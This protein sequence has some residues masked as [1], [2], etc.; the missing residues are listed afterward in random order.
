ME[1]VKVRKPRWVLEYSGKDI[2]ANIAPYILDITYNDVL[3]GESDDVEINLTDADHR[4]KNGWFPQKG[5]EIVLSIGYE[6]AALVKCGTYQVDEVEIN[7]P[8]DTVSLRAL[9]AGVTESLRTKNT[10]AY[11]NKTLG[12]IASG[13]A[14]KH[15]LTL[16]GIISEAKRL[17]RPRRITQR[18][19]TDLEFLKRLGEIEGV[20]FTIKDKQLVWHDQD[21][22]DAANAITVINRTDMIRYTF[23]A[24]TDEVYKACQVSYHDPKTKKLV[25][26]TEKATGVTTGDTLKLTERC[27]GKTDAILKAKAALR[28]RN[29]RQVEGA[30]T[31]SGAPRLAAGGNVD[32]KGIGVLDGSYQIQK[33]RHMMTRSGGYTT[34]VELSTNS[35]HNKSLKNLKN[36]KQVVK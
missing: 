30:V 33:A 3:Q 23:R 26:H 2:S 5:D 8:P 36:E 17:R 16:I 6:G 32:I 15:G 12:E 31:V 13:I 14:K 28:D 21:E 4:W 22:L 10:V 25:T 1:A 7:G 18:T 11:E 20:I 35:A 29:G 9:S 27:E 24:K 19:E 34:E